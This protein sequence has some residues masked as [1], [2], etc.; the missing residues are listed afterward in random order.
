M[1]SVNG[2]KLDSASEQAEESSSNREN[3]SDFVASATSPSVSAPG[4]SIDRSSIFRVPQAISSNT[5]CD[6]AIIGGGIVGLALAYHLSAHHRVVLLESKEIGVGSSGWNGGIL[7]LST[8]IE[9]S[10]LEERLGTEST[11]LLVNALS[12]ELADTK[13]NLALDEQTWQTGQS[14]FAVCK[15]RHLPQIGWESESCANYGIKSQRLDDKDIAANWKG[16]PGALAFQ[17]EHAV[18]P[19]RLLMSLAKR[20]SH[21]GALIFENSNVDRWQ[22]KS[23]GVLISTGAFSVKAKNIVVAS[24]VQG[25]TE[26]FDSS[27]RRRSIPVIG[28][29]M[30]TEPSEHV[31]RM[32]KD[33][34]TI[35]LWDSLRLYHYVHYL[36]D[37]RILVGG[38]EA[39]GVTPHKAL[40][41]ND[42]AVRELWQWASAHHQFAIPPVQ[43][44]WRASLVIPSDGLPLIGIE[45]NG[46]SS[47][48]LAM[49]DGLPFGLLLARLIAQRLTGKENQETAP[50]LD[51]LSRRTPIDMV[52]K[53][54][55]LLPDVPFVRNLALR[56]GIT[57][58]KIADAI[59]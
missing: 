1:D 58:A 51:I 45:A 2:E 26:H 18:H 48:I 7:S 34:G 20:A 28:C 30:V 19:M 27:I 57:A 35:A 10:T 29:V 17:G 12:R 53:M 15:R 59:L 36:P 25:L 13:A 54:L 43:S 9:L 47:K 3:L 33:N 50:L 5:T 46:Q 37:G 14:V 39:P 44:A 6:T 32:I 24:G 49:T 55:A 21:N 41:S 42:A 31:R 16:F 56:I 8:S 40:D 22:T 4:W 11:Q 23:D 52:G 38:G